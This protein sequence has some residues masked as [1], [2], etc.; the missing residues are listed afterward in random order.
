MKRTIMVTNRNYIASLDGTFPKSPVSVPL[1]PWET[2][3]A[4]PP[5]PPPAPPRVYNGR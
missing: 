2:P 3:D 1:L 4:P 5:P